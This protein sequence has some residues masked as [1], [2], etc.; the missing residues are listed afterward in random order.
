MVYTVKEAAALMKTSPQYVR[1]LIASGELP[2]LKLGCLKIR[3][4]AIECLLE[5]RERN[6]N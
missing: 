5:R 2:S 3:K 4:V 6:E 1:K